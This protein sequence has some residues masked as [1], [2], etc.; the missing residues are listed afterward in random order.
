MTSVVADGVNWSKANLTGLPNS[1][2]F[3]SLVVSGG[4]L[5]FVLD[6]ATKKVYKSTDGIIWSQIATNYDVEAIYEV[7]PSA[8]GGDI[9]ITVNNNGSL[10]FAKSKDFSEIKL[11][12][13]VPGNIPIKDYSAAK[14]K[15]TSLSG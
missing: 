7:L 3:S 4:D 5:A 15:M 8:S 11:L 10:M 12:N 2:R 9:L 6:E 14:V 13:S 1:V